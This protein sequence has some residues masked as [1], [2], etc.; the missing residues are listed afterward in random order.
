M[1]QP[2]NHTPGMTLRAIFR[3]VTHDINEILFRIS[4][5]TNSRQLSYFDIDFESANFTEHLEITTKYYYYY[6][7]CF[8]VTP[9]DHIIKLGVNAIEIVARFKIY[10]YFG[11]SGQFTYFN[12]K[13]KVCI[14][15]CVF[16]QMVSDNLGA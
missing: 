3:S 14:Y 10:V 11:H 2:T 8:S 15:F 6:G 12:T 5:T 9:K 4:L 1:Y 7:R 13:T 16:E